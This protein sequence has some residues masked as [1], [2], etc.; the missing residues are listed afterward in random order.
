MF[1]NGVFVLDLFPDGA[2]MKDGR[3]QLGDQLLSINTVMF[4]EMEY[5]KAHETILKQPAGPVRVYN[6]PFSFFFCCH[7]ERK[8]K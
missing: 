8:R 4:K 7:I 6:I 1:Q 5:I 2:A 3:L